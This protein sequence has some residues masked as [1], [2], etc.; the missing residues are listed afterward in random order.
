MITS[1]KT[2][3]LLIEWKNAPYLTKKTV[4]DQIRAIFGYRTKNGKKKRIGG[5]GYIDS[6]KNVKSLEAAQ[7]I[8]S[9][10]PKHSIQNAIYFG[11]E[12]QTILI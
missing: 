9:R 1:T 10:K 12:K 6:F 7:L 4:F 3:R 2:N 8:L 11:I 5:P